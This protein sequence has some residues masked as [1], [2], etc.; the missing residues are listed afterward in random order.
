M[1]QTMNILNIMNEMGYY[2]A[3]SIPKEILPKSSILQSYMFLTHLHCKDFK[4]Q[5]LNI[6]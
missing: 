6:Q 1:Y 4:V 2:Y 5:Y 3:S